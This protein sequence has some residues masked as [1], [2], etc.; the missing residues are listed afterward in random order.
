MTDS[1]RLALARLAEKAALED[2]GVHALDS[3]PSGLRA[4]RSGRESVAGVVCAAVGDGG[5]SLDLHV[6]AMPE[7]LHAMADRV[8]ATVHESA[9]ASGVEDRLRSVSVHVDDI[10]VPAE[11]RV[12]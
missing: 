7:D 10:A 11:S 5:F 9:A 2:P 3:G 1:P 8:R 12:A 6:V 4:T